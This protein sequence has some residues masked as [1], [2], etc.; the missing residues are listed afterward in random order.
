M[1]L[2]F[3]L[4]GRVNEVSSI[5]YMYFDVHVMTAGA[6][7]N[8]KAEISYWWFDSLANWALQQAIVL[9]MNAWTNFSESLR[10]CNQQLENEVGE[11]RSGDLMDMIIKNVDHC[12]K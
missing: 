7:W 8:L 1:N 4:K 9:D 10:K 3:H 12:P 11:S 5:F 6:L 2:K